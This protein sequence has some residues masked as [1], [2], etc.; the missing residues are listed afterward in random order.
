MTDLFVLAA[1]LDMAE[2]MRAL[3]NRHEDL[4]IRQIG[5]SVDK[6]REHDPGCRSDPVTPLRP[7]IGRFA[8]ALVIFDR[9]GCGRERAS[10]EQI[11]ADVEQNLARNGWQ[12]RSKVIVIEPELESWVWVR[13]SRVAN[14]LGWRRSYD[15]LRTWLGRRGLWEAA[16][17][18]P[19]NPKE[20]YRAA[21]REGRKRPSA[22]LFGELAANVPLRR[23]RCPAFNELRR[24]L[25]GWFPPED[26][27][28]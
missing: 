28:E 7:Y 3:L 23:C 12:D 24:T 4:G 6:H 22:A 9:E 27:H 11:Q 17:A 16:T 10:R 15:E 2:T 19:Q 26:V 25:Q 13:S 14:A 21:L 18:K 20:A 5:S 1:D 8:Y